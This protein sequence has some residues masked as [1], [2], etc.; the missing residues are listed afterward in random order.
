MKIKPPIAC[1]SATK[2]TPR[3]FRSLTVGYMTGRPHHFGRP[4]FF[5]NQLRTTTDCSSPS[6][7]CLN[8]CLPVPDETRISGHALCHREIALFS[9]YSFAD[10]I[11]AAQN[12]KLCLLFRGISLL[13]S[14]KSQLFQPGQSLFRRRS[15]SSRR[16]G[17]S[18]R[19][20]CW[21]RC[22]CWHRQR[23]VD[24]QF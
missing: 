15:R 6:A 3:S 20:R 18:H 14:L 19:H 12:P 4:P 23:L 8:D 5:Q 13:L 1:L 10:V 22:G 7:D 24:A 17:R 16:C 9:G 2:P 11:A 21:C